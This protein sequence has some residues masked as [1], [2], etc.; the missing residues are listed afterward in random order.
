M[1]LVCR[2]IYHLTLPSHFFVKPRL[3]RLLGPTFYINTEMF[4]YTDSTLNTWVLH[5]VLTR[6][7][8]IICCDKCELST[9]NLI[10]Y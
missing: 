8:I 7:M 9:L 3:Y 5:L 1:I 4:G 10:D 2:T 6:K